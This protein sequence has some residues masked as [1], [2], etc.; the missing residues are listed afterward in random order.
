MMILLIITFIGVRLR[1]SNIGNFVV[2]RPIQ[3]MTHAD[4]RRFLNLFVTLT[5][6]YDLCR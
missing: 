2:A 5:A 6:S 4:F 1:S 3:S